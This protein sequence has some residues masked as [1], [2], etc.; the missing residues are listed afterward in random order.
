MN[1]VANRFTNQPNEWIWMQSFQ[2]TFQTI[3]CLFRMRQC[4]TN[5]RSFQSLHRLLTPT[6]HGKCHQLLTLIQAVYIV[7]LEQ[8]YSNVGTKCTLTLRK[9]IKILLCVQQANDFSSLPW[10]Y[11]LLSVPLGT[12]CQVLSVPLGMDCQV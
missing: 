5:K 1:Q 3:G 7:P 6:T 8:K 11:S 12:D 9:L 2:T 4:G 10:C